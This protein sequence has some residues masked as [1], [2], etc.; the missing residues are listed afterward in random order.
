MNDVEEDLTFTV[1]TEEDFENGKIQTLDFEMWYDKR[2]GIVRH[3]FFEKPIRTP[4]VVMERSALSCKQKHSILA[5]DLVRRLSNLDMTLGISDHI[6]VINDYTYKLK[7]SGYTRGQAKEIIVS[8]IRG[9]RNKVERRKREG[10]PFYRHAKKTLASRV[11]KKLLGK[12]S[13]YKDTNNKDDTGMASTTRPRSPG[14]RGG[15]GWQKH[16][17]DQVED[18]RKKNQKQ[19]CQTKSVIFVPQTKHSEL[20]ERLREHENEM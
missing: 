17:L 1:E 18:D 10:Q 9:F 8:G 5:N 13:W 7:I 12:T 2:H 3:G 16:A 6:G 14:R 15:G 20:A 11:K 4:L 19:R